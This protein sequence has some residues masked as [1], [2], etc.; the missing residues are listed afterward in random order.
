M[1][2]DRVTGLVGLLLSVLIGAVAWG[3]PPSENDSILPWS[4][5]QEALRW[6]VMGP[7]AEVPC[8]AL[9]FTL[10]GPAEARVQTLIAAGYAVSAVSGNH[11]S[12]L[13][14][15]TLYIDEE[16][17]P[18]A[19][20]FVRSTLPYLENWHSVEWQGWTDEQYAMCTRT[21]SEDAKDADASRTWAEAMRL[22]EEGFAAYSVD[23][24]HAALAL[25]DEALAIVR[26]LNKPDA[27]AMIL[28]NVGLC[29]ESLLDYD[30]AISCY[31]QARTLFEVAEDWDG[32]A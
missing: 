9:V 29:H 5:Q 17:G 30:S 27:E 32:V 13:A 24:F 19:L 15:I 18:D 3:A 26:G 14:P 4:L 22:W 7:G 6:E 10:D 2:T 8:E 12:V 11:V 16:H 23:S 20:G 25:Y 21:S 28:T 31:E 1:R